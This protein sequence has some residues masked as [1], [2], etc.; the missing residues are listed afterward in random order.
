M[1]RYTHT[2]E[3][4]LIVEPVDIRMGIIRITSPAKDFTT[5]HSPEI[6]YDVHVMLNNVEAHGVH[7]GTV[8]LRLHP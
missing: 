8:N 1:F 3:F 5:F 4:V 6:R 7:N 2:I